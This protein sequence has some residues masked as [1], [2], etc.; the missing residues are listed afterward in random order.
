[1]RPRPAVVLSALA[2]AVGVS[3]ALA[4]GLGAVAI[5]PGTIVQVLAH[6]FGPG[7]N[8]GAGQPAEEAILLQIR[9]PRVVAAALVGAALATAGA[10]L[11]G[12]L[13]N[14]LADPYVIGTS[15]GAALGATVATLAAAPGFAATF[16]LIPAL[17]F[18]GAIGTA[19]LVY[20]LAR[21]SG[22]TSIT[23]LLLAG[24]AVNAVLVAAMNFLLSVDDRLQLRMRALFAW[25]FGGIAVAGWDQLALVAPGILALVALAWPLAPALNALAMGEEG[26]AYLGVE[27][28]QVRRS[29]LAVAALLTALAVT[30]SGLIGFVGLVVPHAL[31]MVLGPEHRL[32]LP[33]SALG[34]ALFLLWTDALARTVLA[35]AELPVGVLTGLVGGPFFLYLLGRARGSYLFA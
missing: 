22:G 8:P 15:A 14:P 35:P 2:L 20:R 29:L 1:M 18:A 24:M 9:L 34:G 17:A 23:N 11:Q 7:A 32:L 13:R 6:Q 5:P 10:L 3:M 19:L 25:L 4:A 27:V 30:V 28:V 12:L 16:G 21:A 26:A 33:A 31:R